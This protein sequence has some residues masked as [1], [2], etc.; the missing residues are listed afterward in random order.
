MPATYRVPVAILTFLQVGSLIVLSV[1]SL[2][3][4][5]WLIAPLRQV[6]AAQ[7]GVLRFNAGSGADTAC[8]DV[9]AGESKKQ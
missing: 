7:H 8:R 1:G 3:L 5:H 4:R 2:R 9:S 6:P